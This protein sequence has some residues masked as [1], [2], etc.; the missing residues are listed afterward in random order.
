M[1]TGGEFDLEDIAPIDG[2]LFDGRPPMELEHVEIG[3]LFA[4]ANLDWALIDP[5]IFGAL[6]ERF[7]DTDER[8][9]IGA[10]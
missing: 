9:Q 4:A 5:A 1:A 2:G 10:H 7:L 3:M 6:F 8:A